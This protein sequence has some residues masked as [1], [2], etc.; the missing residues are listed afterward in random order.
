MKIE[1]I[2]KEAAKLYRSMDWL[3]MQDSSKRVVIVPKEGAIYDTLLDMTFKI[4]E[5]TQ[6]S[7]DSVYRFTMEALGTIADADAD[8]LTEDNIQELSSSIEADVYTSELT[9]WLGENN[10]H[11]YYLTQALELGVTDGFQAL[12]MAQ[13]NAKVE[14][15]DIVC[16]ELLR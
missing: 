3:E 16:R 4:S 13:L 12:A 8:G 14:V 2:T 11:V 10:N 1:Q 6:L 15:F 9:D 5:E 7:M